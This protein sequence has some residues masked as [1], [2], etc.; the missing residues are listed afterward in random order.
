M[1]QYYRIKPT[2]NA[3]QYNDENRDEIFAELWRRGHFSRIVDGELRTILDG[4][5]DWMTII[6][7]CIFDL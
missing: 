3:I 6:P 4:D 7:K 2:V 1:D 5:R